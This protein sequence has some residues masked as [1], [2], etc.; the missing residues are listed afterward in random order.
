MPTSPFDHQR[1][2]GSN[3]IPCERESHRADGRDGMLS[4]RQTRTPPGWRCSR[5]QPREER[6]QLVTLPADH[7]F[8]RGRY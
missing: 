2:P 6:L 1:Q 4:P 3:V 8:L 7:R 5:E